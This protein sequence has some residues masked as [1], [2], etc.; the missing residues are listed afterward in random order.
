MIIIVATLGA[1]VGSVW[2]AD[3]LTVRTRSAGHDDS[4]AQQ[5]LLSLATGTLLATAFTHLLP[6][7][8]ESKV[9]VQALFLTLLVGLVFFFLLSKVALRHREP[10]PVDHRHRGAGWPLLIGDGVH[11]FGDGVLIASALVADV[12]AG[13]VAAIS[14]L[15]HEVP[16]HMGDLVVLREGGRRGPARLKVSMA[17]S[18]TAL[19]GVAGYFLASRLQTWQPFLV[20]LAGSSFIY[21]ALSNLI[22][23][24]QQ[25]QT[26]RETSAQ[27]VWLLL[28]I[29]LVALV[30]GIAHE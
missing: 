8:F 13:I 24:L 23:R 15:V 9:D 20:T 4:D 5:R 1:G 16:H 22:P 14:V 10:H 28:G 26:S 6:E 29:A 12:R 25:R 7:A 3:L 11:G 18:I 30:G 19:G 21:V 17:G 27:M 2:V